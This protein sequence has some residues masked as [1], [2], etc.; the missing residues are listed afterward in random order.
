MPMS[1]QEMLERRKEVTFQFFGNEMHVSYWVEQMT[2]EFRADL[3][4]LSRHS[5]RL[6]QR[7]QDLSAKVASIQE[8]E[9][10]PEGD[11][12]DAE[13]ERAIAQ[14]QADDAALKIQ[15][16]E[17]LFKILASWDVMDGPKP[18]SITLAS[19]AQIPVD[20]ESTMIQAILEESKPLGEAN[21]QQNMKLLPYSSK[22]KAK[23]VPSH[24]HQIG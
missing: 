7:A 24:R 23:R 9:G 18:L 19:L 4:R 6:Q 3:L 2:K 12:E 20:F 16:D 8:Q 22:Q 10:T 15:I 13:A 11:A 14:L 5:L 17:A 21:G 1:F